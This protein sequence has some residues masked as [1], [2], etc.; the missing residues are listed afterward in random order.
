MISAVSLVAFLLAVLGLRH[1]RRAVHARQAGGRSFKVPRAYSPPD[2]A[3]PDSD[4]A[5]GRA[6]RFRAPR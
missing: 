6:F 4:G 5:G 2:R 1:E 3:R